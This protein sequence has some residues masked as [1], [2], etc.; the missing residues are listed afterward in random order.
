MK[1]LFAYRAIDG[2]AGGL[3]RMSNAIMNEM[4]LR[5]HDVQFLTLDHAQAQS[6]YPMDERIDWYKLNMG[7]YRQRAGWKMRWKRLQAMRDY[8]IRSK[9]DVIIA[10]QDGSFFSTKVASLFTG[11]PVVLAERISPQHFD[12]KSGRNYRGL[13]WQTYRWAKN[14]T[15]QCES[16][17]PMYP[18]YLRKRLVCISNPVFQRDRFAQP[19]KTRDRKKLLCVG[20]LCYQKNQDVLIRAF[21]NLASEFPEWDLILAGDGEHYKA[22]ALLADAHPQIRLLG[23]VRD[24]EALY[25]EANL[26]CIPSRWEGFPNALAEAL[27][28]GVPAIGYRDC[29]GVR[30]LIQEGENGL[31]AA[32]ALDVQPLEAALRRLMTDDDLR[33]KMGEKAVR[34]V[35]K[36]KPSLIFDQWEAFFKR[37]VH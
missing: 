6:Y 28:Y 11:I 20:R 1:I 2:I 5:G 33:A 32:G 10:F 30:D 17:K 12:Y 27:S 18:A 15:I 29:G 16:Y 23:A 34:S 19:G 31:L 7:D 26:F 3:E 13:I 4:C 25:L 14:I 35:E 21:L 36:Y 9:P 22:L 8:I 24:V 37:F